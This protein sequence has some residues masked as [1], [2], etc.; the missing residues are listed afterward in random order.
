[1]NNT[2]FTNSGKK[3]FLDLLSTHFLISNENY[4][5]EGEDCG[6][7]AYTCEAGIMG[8]F[9]GCGGLGSNICGMISEKTEAFV[10]SRAVFSALRDWFYANAASG[11][12]WDTE[13]L[14][15][16]AIAKLEL[17]RKHAGT[18][19]V[20]LRGSLVRPFPSTIA[21]VAFRPGEGE[22]LTCHVWAGDS[23]TYVLDQDGLGQISRDDI[24]GADAMQNLSRDS[25]LKNLISVDQRFVLHRAELAVTQPCILFCAT[26]GCFGYVPSPM[27]F[28]CMI[29]SALEGADNV[30]GWQKSLSDSISSQAGD[31]QTIAVAAFGFDSFAQLKQYYAQRYHTIQEIVAKFDKADSAEQQQLWE[32]YKPNYYRYA[33]KKE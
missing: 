1:M 26:D 24:K 13:D 7:E 21:S 4:E 2:F 9:D 16:R 25:A 30:D 14:R 3:D 15:K 22:L 33:A 10:T 8:V 27:A 5:G 28:E 12:R 31:D 23:R 29:L 18:P 17:C 11:Y 32:T 6:F 20:M 19:E